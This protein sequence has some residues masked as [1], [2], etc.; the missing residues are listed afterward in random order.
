MS[1]TATER[2]IRKLK[3]N[4]AFVSGYLDDLVDNETRLIMNNVNNKGR[5]SQ[6]KF[7]LNQGWSVD[8]IVHEG[9]RVRKLI[10][11]HVKGF[12]VRKKK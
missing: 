7:L 6:V 3:Y 12:K 4:K 1:E 11:K 9:K 2:V 10:V 5:T 8:E